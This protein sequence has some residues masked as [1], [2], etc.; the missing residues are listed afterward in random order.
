MTLALARVG[1][2]GRRPGRMPLHPTQHPWN[3]PSCSAGTHGEIGLGACVRVSLTG[4]HSRLQ[5]AEEGV[6]I[7][8][9]APDTE[10]RSTRVAFLR[11]LVAP[12][13]RY[14]IQCWSRR[15][16][17]SADTLVVVSL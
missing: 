12:E 2:S 14:V 16:L 1:E 15:V 17:R 9:V 4:S 13:P 5:M 8:V 3:T 10:V 6:V 11:T 7:E